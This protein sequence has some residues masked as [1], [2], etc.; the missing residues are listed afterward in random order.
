[1]KIKKLE[2][3]NYEVEKEIIKN[4]QYSDEQLN[5][6]QFG[7][8]DNWEFYTDSLD[9]EGVISFYEFKKTDADEYI[10]SFFEQLERS[11]K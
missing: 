3:G 1:M 11:I 9:E 5:A 2:N 6:L 7:G 8:V 10:E 4:L